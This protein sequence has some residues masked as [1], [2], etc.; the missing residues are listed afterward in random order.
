MVRLIDTCIIIDY[1]RGN[2]NIDFSHG[3]ILINPVVELEIL[4]GVRNKREQKDAL[5]TMEYFQRI[6]YSSECFNLAKI[7]ILR[8]SLSHSLKLPDALIAASCL[9]YDLPLWTYNIKD[10]AYIEGMKIYPQGLNDD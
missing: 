10:F 3:E 2:S 4:Q 8:Y 9:I 6:E 5:R 7:L 1:L